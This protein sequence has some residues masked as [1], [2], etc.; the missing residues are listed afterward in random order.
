M[1]WKIYLR[2]RMAY[3]PTVAATEAGFFLEIDPV[4]VVPADEAEAVQAAIKR[5]L[6][7]GNPKVPTPTRAA[8]PKPVI[9]K[10]ANV[11]S[12]S[13]FENGTETWTV[14]QDDNGSYQ[15]K[16]GRRRSDAGWEDDPAKI[17]ASPDGATADQVSERVASLIQS[18]LGPVR[19]VK[20]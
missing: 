6:G 5:A 4:E 10:Y 9:L 17:E 19:I 11:N 12:W 16:R 8:A 14:I 1:L 18:A 3:V 15:I 2:K 7:R 13:A 20:I